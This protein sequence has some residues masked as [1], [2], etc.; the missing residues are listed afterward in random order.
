MDVVRPVNDSSR[1]SL[2]RGRILHRA[3][4]NEPTQEYLLQIPE[5]PG[6]NMPVF[7]SVHGVSRNAYE[8]ARVFSSYCNERGIVLVIPIFTAEQHPDYQRLGR[9]GRGMRVDRLLDRFLYE[10]MSL[11]G[12]DVTRI[13]LF[14]FSG[15]AQFAHRYLMAHPH[16]VAR[17][18]IGAAGWYTFPDNRQR[19]PYGIR[20]ARKLRGVNFNPEQFLRV[21]VT[22]LVGKRDTGPSNLRST[23]RCNEQQGETRV[24]RAR[25][26]VVAM[27]KAAAAHALE[28]RVELAEVAAAGHSFREFCEKG[29]LVEIVCNALFPPE[30]GQREAPAHDGF[31]HSAAGVAFVQRLPSEAADEPSR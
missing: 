4:R 15:G 13:H 24:E 18:V 5:S 14:G 28:P 22:V 26:W 3:L 25:N 21:P 9:R 6:V 2:P 29:A 16:R 10:A 23:R 12:A 1:W 11:T 19:Y 20:S 17:A 7:V 8:Q 30:I 31:D 27:R